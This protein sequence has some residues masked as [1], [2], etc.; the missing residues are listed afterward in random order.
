MS[1]TEQTAQRPLEPQSTP[2]KLDW[3]DRRPLDE[4]NFGASKENSAQITDI[5]R[6]YLAAAGVKIAED[7]A[8]LGCTGLYAARLKYHQAQLA[9]EVGDAEAAAQEDTRF[10]RANMDGAAIGLTCFVDMDRYCLIHDTIGG[11]QK[12][13]A[14]RHAEHV[15]AISRELTDKE[16]GH[17]AYV[18]SAMRTRGRGGGL[19]DRLIRTVDQLTG[20]ERPDG[21]TDV[22]GAE[23]ADINADP[24]DSIAEMPSRQ[25]HD[26][27]PEQA[28]DALTDP[29]AD[30]VPTPLHTINS[31]VKPLGP[32]RSL[33]ALKADIQQLDEA[34]ALLPE[35]LR[36]ALLPI[37]IMAAE[38][39]TQ[40]PW[41]CTEHGEFTPH[42]RFCVAQAVVSGPFKPKLL[43]ASGAEKNS[44]DMNTIV[45]LDDVGKTLPE[46]LHEQ[47]KAEV[48]ET[49]A[50]F[51]KAAVWRRKN[52][53]VKD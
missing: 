27:S 26:E 3:I 17:V 42:C 7:I 6:G 45:D 35:A 43:V 25:R 47:E 36:D 11:L 50:V 19:T 44:I 40:P 24:R 22:E 4:V 38:A 9:D 28:W 53:L 2:D 48:S 32:V 52:Q 13:Q 31:V 5:V 29:L 10:V 8:D 49:V 46:I 21:V 41:T 37:I 30:E 14:Q 1:D 15:E 20:V 23:G 12:G 33:L 18:E 16:R 34:L 39:N 51:V